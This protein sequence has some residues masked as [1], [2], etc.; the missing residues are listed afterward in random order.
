MA[1]LRLN[2]GFRPNLEVPVID[3]LL[4]LP[5]RCPHRRLTRPV[6]PITNVVQQHSQRY[7]VCL[8]GANDEWEIVN[9]NDGK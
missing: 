3:T 2:S 8:T 7:I 6:A 1:P 4:N 9:R 5:F